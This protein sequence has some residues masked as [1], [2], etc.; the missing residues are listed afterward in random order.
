MSSC[1]WEEL[2]QGLGGT[3]TFIG[4]SPVREMGAGRPSTLGLKGTIGVLELLE[5]KLFTGRDH[6]GRGP[7]AGRWNWDSQCL[8]LL[9]M[10]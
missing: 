9:N 5:P 6:W 4:G 8:R 2:T 10:A 3:R 7:R 1:D